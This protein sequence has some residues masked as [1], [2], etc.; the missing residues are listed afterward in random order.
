MLGS[1]SHT[2]V[3]L[4]AQVSAGLCILETVVLCCG[5]VARSAGRAITSGRTTRRI[6][7]E[8]SPSMPLCSD[9]H[10]VGSSILLHIPAQLPLQ[11]RVQSPL[12]RP[13]QCLAE[14]AP[15]EACHVLK[16][17]GTHLQATSEASFFGA[18]VPLCMQSGTEL[19]QSR[20]S[21][22][23]TPLHTTT[24]YSTASEGEPRLDYRSRHTY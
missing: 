14:G 20:E 18:D 4:A 10:W 5:S 24:R 19:S 1:W 16:S 13:R 21:L 2:R 6:L 17:E 3:I 15:V 12:M 7:P 11:W 8:W 22:M 23:R 9:Y